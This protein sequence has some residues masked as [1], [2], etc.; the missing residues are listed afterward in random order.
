MKSKAIV[1]TE[2]CHAIT[3]KRWAKGNQAGRRCLHMTTRGLYCHQHLK[4]LKGFCVMK[5]KTDPKSQL[6]LV[7]T[8]NIPNDHVVTRFDGNKLNGKA[9]SKNPYQLQIKPSTYIDG[10]Q[11]NTEGLGRWVKPANR[12]KPANAEFVVQNDKPYIYSTKY[13]HAGSEIVASRKIVVPKAPKPPK[14][15]KKKSRLIKPVKPRV[16][17]EEARFQLRQ[18]YQELGEPVPIIMNDNKAQH[19]AQLN[20]LLK[21]AQEKLKR[22]KAIIPNIRIKKALINYR[23]PIPPARILPPQ[24]PRRV[25]PKKKN[26]PKP[27][28]GPRSL[29]KK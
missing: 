1:R 11:T 28:P 3:S 7:T 15:P 24:P 20:R 12:I 23:P 25:I 18:V 8:K 29:A 13:I 22:K 21:Q 6:G 10:S 2:R 17:D 16:S 27:G 19:K 5:T 4:Q 9:D 14:P 26:L